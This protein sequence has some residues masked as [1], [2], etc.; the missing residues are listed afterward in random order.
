MFG[1]K[2]DRPAGPDPTSPTPEGQAGYVP[3]DDVDG[4]DPQGDAGQDGGAGETDQLLSTLRAELDDMSDRLKRTMADFQNYQ[5]RAMQN[6]QE[7]RRQGIS[8]VVMSVVPVLDHF[9]LALNQKADGPAAG[10]LEGVKVI[11]SE[12]IRALERQGVRVI[13]PAPNDPFDPMRHEAIMQQPAEG[14]EPG[15]ISATFQPGFELNDRMIRSAK[16]AVAPV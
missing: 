3:I 15:H 9:D 5:R 16:V 8:A 11:R 4:I 13:S 1:R 14:V 10:I 12:L 7:A 2:P 6:E